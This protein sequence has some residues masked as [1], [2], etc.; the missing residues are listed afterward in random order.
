[1]RY[2]GFY[3]EVENRYM[4]KVKLILLLTILITKLSVAQYYEAGVGIGLSLYYGDLNAPDLSTNLTNSRFAIQGFARYLPHAN[5]G[6]RANLMIGRLYGDDNKSKEQ[7][8]K[9]RNLRFHSILV[10]ASVM[11]EY[12]LFGYD[13]REGTQLFSPYATAGVALFYFNPKADYQ[14]QTYA[15]QPLGTEGQGLPG[16]PSKYSRLSF[17]I[18]FGGGIKFKINDRWN[19]NVELLARKT[20]TDYIDDVSTNYVDINELSAA[21]GPISAALSNRI[22]EALGS[23]PVNLPGGKRGGSG[24]DDYYFSF[25]IGVSANL[26]TIFGI[27]KSEHTPDCPHY[28]T[29]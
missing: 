14:G 20:F 29:N 28:I 6:V 19:F 24:V 1:M 4:I 16:M 15:L 9:T 5:Y 17:A 11:G 27:G 8:Q 7:F 21:N 18:P 22:G 12:Y 10:E 13:A 25:M 3:H 2:P 26:E 23:E